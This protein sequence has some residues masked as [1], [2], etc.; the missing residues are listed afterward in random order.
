MILA[1]QKRQQQTRGQDSAILTQISEI[2]KR[3]FNG[4]KEHCLRRAAKRSGPKRQ[5]PQQAFFKTANWRGVFDHIR[6][7]LKPLK[8]KRAAHCPSTLSQDEICQS[9][10]SPPIMC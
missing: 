3:F 4:I 5:R 10:T 2:E 6:G 8:I 1:K 7:P 9:R